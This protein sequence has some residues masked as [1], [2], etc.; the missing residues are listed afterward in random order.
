MGV[1]RFNH[2][3]CVTILLPGTFKS[4]VVLWS[5]FVLPQQICQIIMQTILRTALV[6]PSSL[7][8]RLKGTLEVGHRF[9]LA[10]I[11]N[12]GVPF[13]LAHFGWAKG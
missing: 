11:V 9:L 12:Q 2:E 13:D 7:Q 3:Q 5:F 8:I 1:I 4:I 10:A 6:S